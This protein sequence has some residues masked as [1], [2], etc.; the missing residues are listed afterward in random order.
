MA[1]QFRTSS[2]MGEQ[3]P[4]LSVHGGP[5]NYGRSF[6]AKELGSRE[7]PTMTQQNP[8]TRWTHLSS[9][10]TDG[11]PGFPGPQCKQINQMSTKTQPDLFSNLTFACYFSWT[12]QKSPKTLICFPRAKREW[13][14]SNILCW[15]CKLCWKIIDSW[16]SCWNLVK[17]WE[18]A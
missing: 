11:F 7:L 9:R 17:H 5:R 16:L 4:V 18:T 13:I 10:V 12:R 1:A 15:I 6:I 2:F 8:G 3:E 14:K